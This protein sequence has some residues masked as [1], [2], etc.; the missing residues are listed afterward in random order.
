MAL[1]VGGAPVGP[2]APFCDGSL[3]LKQWVLTAVHYVHM[4]DAQGN[5]GDL[6]PKEISGM[7]GSNIIAADRGK[8]IAG[9]GVFRHSTRVD[10]AFDAGFASAESTVL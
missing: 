4:Q 8:V 7:L 1:L 9:K 10:R 6:N 5:W 3:I 2:D